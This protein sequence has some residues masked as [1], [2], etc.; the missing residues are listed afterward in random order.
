M[1]IN[2][3]TIKAFFIL[4]FISFK[5]SADN[6]LTDF[7][8]I[9][10][11]ILTFP[12]GYEDASQKTEKQVIQLMKQLNPDRQFV[13]VK[14]LNKFGQLLFGYQN[15]IAVPFFN[16]L[17]VNEQWLKTLSEE[18]QKFVLGRCVTHMHNADDYI[19]YNYFMAILV[20][21]FMQYSKDDALRD[22]ESL[23]DKDKA[24]YNTIS[25]TKISNL[26][27]QNFII[28]SPLVLYMQY[29]RRKLE[30]ETDIKTATKFNCAKGGIEVL[31]SIPQFKHDG[32]PLN[33][34]GST[35]PILWA[36]DY[37]LPNPFIIRTDFY[38]PGRLVLQSSKLGHIIQNIPILH[39]L[40]QYPRLQER[41]NALRNIKK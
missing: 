40:W 29:L 2:S 14:K 34:I 11:T 1:L 4:C 19:F 27:L 24:K 31:Q 16:Y 39:Y 10:G 23:P 20:H 5:I 13:A 3:K 17:L 18:S 12:F 35:L 22:Y 7:K 33:Q 37:F 30:A 32:T 26:D 28:I 6:T 41:I 15:T 9:V 8:K 21:L 36:I 25:R 38:A